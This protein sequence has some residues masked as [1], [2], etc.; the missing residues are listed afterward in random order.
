[1]RSNGSD[2]FKVAMG[3]AYGGVT[4]D[5]S[6]STDYGDIPTTQSAWHIL[7]IGSLVVPPASLPEGATI[8]T[9]T[10]RIAFYNATNG[11]TGES[12][13]VDWVLLLPVDGGVAYA[14][15]AAATNVVV[16]DTVTNL[17]SLS[18]WDTSDIFQSRPEQRGGMV[19]VDPGGT[20]VYLVDDDGADAGIA[21]GWKVAVK[22]VPQYLHV[23]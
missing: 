19:M 5:P 15:K 12:L 22:V 10:L 1:V 2:N 18:L 23:G 7:D 21:E 8:G 20:R 11:N 4:V 9:L 6:V 3:H 16:L 17:A 14:S 13:D